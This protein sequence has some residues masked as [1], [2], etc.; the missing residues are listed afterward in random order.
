MIHMG[1]DANVLVDNILLH[2]IAIESTII[3]TVFFLLNNRII[4]NGY[5]HFFEITS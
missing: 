4:P 3:K 2:F 5:L 1:D